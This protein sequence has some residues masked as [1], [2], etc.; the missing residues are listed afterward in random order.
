MKLERPCRVIIGFWLLS[1]FGLLNA[2]AQNASGP[3]LAHDDFFSTWFARV[4]K[5]QSEQ[6]S[7][8]TPVFTT[9]PRLDEEIHYDQSYQ[10]QNGARVSNYGSSKGLELIPVQNVQ[11]N[12]GVPP[13]ISRDNAPGKDG[14]GDT[15]FLV[16]YRLLSANQDNGDYVF[17]TFLGLT[18]PTGSRRQTSGRYTLTPS[19]AGGKGWGNFDIQ[20]TLGVSLP[21]NDGTSRRGPAAPIA[22][23][24][25]FQYR[26]GKFV[27]PEVEANY[28]YWPDGVNEG[29][30]QLF[31]S[32]GLILGR[33]PI[34]RRLRL[35]VGVGY[36]VAVTARPLVH[37]NFDVTVRLPF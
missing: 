12:L 4:S 24:T 31:I 6:P 8:M 21:G 15:S 32:P 14:F 13:W 28:T 16:K 20:S 3:L 19:I 25:S 17:T 35:V 18:V 30:E 29:R 2:G 23:N 11:L 27:W 34:W 36:Q 10:S 1:A 9:T 26:L 5:I 22:L 33:F 37:N 7:W